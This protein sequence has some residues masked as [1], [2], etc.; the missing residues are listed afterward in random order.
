MKIALTF[1]LCILAGSSYLSA[2]QD[3]L[4][5]LFENQTALYN[6]AFS[7]LL[8]VHHGAVNYRDQ[9]IDMLNAPRTVFVTD[10]HRLADHHGVGVNYT[11]DARGFTETQSASLN[12]NYQFTFGDDPETQH[13]L[14]IGIS[15]GF[16]H[17][18][19]RPEWIPPSTYNEGSLPGSYQSIE[20]NLDFGVAY[21]WKGLFVGHSLRHL[22]SKFLKQ[23][24]FYTPALHYSFLGGYNFKLGAKKYFELT[25]QLLILTD[26]VRMTANPQ[27]QAAYSIKGKQRVWFGV[28]YRS[29][30]A[31]Q[32][33]AGIDIYKR[34]RL[35]YAYE[36]FISQLSLTAGATHELVLAYRLDK[37]ADRAAP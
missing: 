2:Q 20:F 4:T 33:M 19:L 10:N 37:K 27:V 26:F 5:A 16:F 31:L 14:A 17:F 28:G 21:S 32:C 9:W 34:F 11:Y 25:P 12:Y 3:P 22:Q 18:R 7:G 6:P 24:S 23:G 30:S 29:S 36:K 13:R 35:G 15:P 8:D 1:T